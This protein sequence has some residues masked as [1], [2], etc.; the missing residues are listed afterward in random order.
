MVFW[1]FNGVVSICHA[2]ILDIVGK[3]TYLAMPRCRV[4]DGVIPLGVVLL[5]KLLA[6]VPQIAWKSK[7]HS[8]EF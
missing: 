8:R 6:V 5:E 7:Y 3:L 1:P 2:A 4:E